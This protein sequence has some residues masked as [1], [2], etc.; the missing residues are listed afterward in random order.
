ML[1]IHKKSTKLN[2]YLVTLDLKEDFMNNIIQLKENNKED[3]EKHTWGI[4]PLTK[5]YDTYCYSGRY[6]S[7]PS[8]Q[9]DVYTCL[10]RYDMLRIPK[11]LMIPKTKN[12]KENL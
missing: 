9:E 2:I 8:E 4:L 1:G 7:V 12:S 10:K 5:K 3:N 11:R 6:D